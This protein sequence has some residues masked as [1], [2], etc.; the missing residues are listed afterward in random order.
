MAA[1][2]TIA[3][4]DEVS[5]LT[6]SQRDWK[7]WIQQLLLQA[8]EKIGKQNP[9]EM[10]ISFVDQERIHAINKKYRGKDRATDVISFAIEDGDEG[11]N[12]ASFEADPNFVEEI[13]DLFIC[14]DVVRVHSREYGTG[15][16]REFGYTCV[17]GFLHLNGYDHIKADEAKVMFGLQGEILAEYGLPLHRN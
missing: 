3:F 13:G 2:L 11:L 1:P 5:F 6:S 17:H 14:P 15:F 7:S 8:R 10:S 16:D 4:N 9:L 12:L